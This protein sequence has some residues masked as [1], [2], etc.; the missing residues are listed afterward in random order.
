[1]EIRLYRGGDMSDW[2]NK[3]FQQ[4]ETELKFKKWVERPREY[5]KAL[6][7][8]EVVSIEECIENALNTGNHAL[9]AKMFINRSEWKS[10]ERFP[11]WV[12]EVAEPCGINIHSIDFVSTKE[13]RDPAISPDEM[14]YV[15]QS[16]KSG[17]IAQNKDRLSNPRFI[18]RD[19]LIQLAFYLNWDGDTAN[20][21]LT[22]M[23]ERGLYPLDI[24]DAIETIYLNYFQ[25]KKI[26]YI[27][28]LKT[29]KGEINR[30]LIQ[31]SGENLRWIDRSKEQESIGNMNKGSVRKPLF[32]IL[33]ESR[34]G[35]DIEEELASLKDTYE[36]S[37]DITSLEIPKNHTLT[38]F[39]TKYF[40][41]R[42]ADAEDVRSYYESGEFMPYS[43]FTERQYGY[44]KRTMDYL[45]DWKSYKKNLMGSGW[46]LDGNVCYR[47]E[48]E[49][50]KSAINTSTNR[51]L[52]KILKCAGE[53][54]KAKEDRSKDSGSVQTISESREQYYKA[55]MDAVHYIET[56]D[57]AIEDLID[58]KV[59]A[60][61]KS[62]TRSYIEGK[63]V[64]GKGIVWKKN[65]HQESIADYTPEESGD[66]EVSGYMV[67]ELS[68]KKNIM[69][70]GIATGHE[71]DLGN[72][73]CLAGYWKKNWYMELVNGYIRSEGAEGFLP[74]RLD[75]LYLYAMEYRDAVIK[76]CCSSKEGILDESV[77]ERLRRDFPMRELLTII[78]RDISFAY[79]VCEKSIQ[80]AVV[81][82]ETRK[83]AQY[84]KRGDNGERRKG[85]QYYEEAE[86]VYE[87]MRKNM[88]FPI[89]WTTVR[90]KPYSLDRESNPYYERKECEKL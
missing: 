37:F 11:Q 30:A 38:L 8:P 48:A 60:A 46:T 32:S 25:D 81:D 88:L 77:K 61:K 57:C 39:M 2:N 9:F 72:Y 73:L 36:K 21:F 44:L 19:N 35:I 82:W 50:R 29:V 71:E 56:Q 17:W 23:G 33:H 1:M 41:K 90:E 64:R 3:S 79:T 7:A 58:R 62:V 28:K 31:L 76:Q 43:V 69:Q 14:T 54:E 15:I 13:W 63:P 40:Q 47:E 24:V 86:K 55:C 66:G 5:Y 53:Y 59:G 89:E 78:S 85:A 74:D 22:D 68:N 65:E 18:H 52:D 42:L 20:M 10:E 80:S 4:I 12:S 75:A 27:D 6:K 70:Y 87:R 51:V 67:Q 83:S 26:D 34:L 49:S 84:N 45:Y 16:T